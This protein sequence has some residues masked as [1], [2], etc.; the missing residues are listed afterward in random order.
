[1]EIKNNLENPL[2]TKE[3]QTRFC[4]LFIVSIMKINKQINK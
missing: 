2:N 3:G 1:M 4:L